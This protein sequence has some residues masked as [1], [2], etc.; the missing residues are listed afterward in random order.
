MIAHPPCTF[1]CKAQYHILY[2]SPGR[3]AKMLEA[4]EFVKKIKNL[5]VPKIA[6]ENPIGILYKYIGQPTQITYS[7]WFGDPHK[8]DICLWLKNLPPLIST[9]YNPRK[10]YVGNHVNGRMSQVN[11]SHIKNK[12]F[13]LVAEAMAVQ[14][15]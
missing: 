15:T 9:C 11:K 5:D 2:T 8:K 12:F 1:L 10:Q 6:I 13:P 7:N 14:W 3:W 4:V